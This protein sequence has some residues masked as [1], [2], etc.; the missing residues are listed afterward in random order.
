MDQM[1]FDV[2]TKHLMG[3]KWQKIREK[4]MN[5][6]VNCDDKAKRLTMHPGLLLAEEREGPPQGTLDCVQKTGVIMI[7]KEGVAEPDEAPAM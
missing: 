4:L 2:Q 5:Y 1:W 6:P 3:I 7:K